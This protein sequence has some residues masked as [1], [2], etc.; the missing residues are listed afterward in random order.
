MSIKKRHS[1]IR[2]GLASSI[3]LLYLQSC[4]VP[5]TLPEPVLL[6]LSP[7]VQV[8]AP[9]PAPKKGPILPEVCKPLSLAELVD[10]ALQNHPSTKD[11]WAQARIAAANLGIAGSAYFPDIVFDG[12]YQNNRST[13]FGQHNGSISNQSSIFASYTTQV[14]VSYLL[15]DFG[16]GRAAGV[17]SAK[18]ALL[19]AEWNYSWTVQTVLLGVVQ[20][21][22]QYLY[23]KASVG[24]SEAD[25]RDALVNLKA[26]EVYHAAGVT[27]QV[28]L[29]QAKAQMAQAELNLAT[30]KG[31]LGIAYATLANRMGI[32]PNICFEVFI[33]EARFSSHICCDVE[34]LLEDARCCRSDLASL[35][36]SI[37]AQQEATRQARAQL[38]PTLTGNFVGGTT[39]LQ[40]V[41]NVG[42]TYSTTLDFD[43]PLFSGFS[44][45]NA[46]RAAEFQIDEQVAAFLIQ[47][48]AAFLA[49]VTDYINVKTAEESLIY[50]R[51][52]LEYAEKFY[53]ATLMNYRAGTGSFLD[54]ATA[55]TTLSNARQQEVQSVTN[56]FVSLASLAYDR[57]VLVSSEPRQIGCD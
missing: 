10:V 5:L 57:G 53:D 26:A 40:N 14:S 16:D 4:A 17:S 12:I 24:V 25:L 9:P 48:N 31:N 20:A 43:V 55:H 30:A 34:Q 22:Y 41:G 8:S 49:V 52:Y 45:I 15:W 21:Y 44:Q 32:P 19:A 33:P 42:F 2:W 11:A 18:F 50:S 54:L 28:D 7:C 6:P 51:E 1:S 47:E 39:N 27:T 23:A 38:W 37:R 56:W 3:A 13:G 29:F 46:I 36:A 35:R